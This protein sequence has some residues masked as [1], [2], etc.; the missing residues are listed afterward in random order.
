MATHDFIKLRGLRENNLKG[1][2]LDLP[3]NQFIVVTGLSGSGKS[4]LAFDTIFAEGQRRYTET[5]SPYTRQFLE[6]MNKP[7]ADS[8]EGIPPAIALSQ[9]NS[10]RTSRSTVGS[11]TEIADYLKLLF[12][13]HAELR[14][15]V[16][17]QKIQPW[18]PA[19]IVAELLARHADT[20][21][22]V[23]FDLAFSASISWPAIV[24]TLQ[25]QG[26]TRVLWNDQP[27]RLDDLANVTA[28]APLTISVIADRLTVSAETQSRLA[29]AIQTAL[30]HGKGLV[31]IRPISPIRPIRP[32]TYADHYLDPATHH[33]YTAPTPALF[34][35]NSPIGACPVCKGFGRTVTIDYDLA[36]PD[37]TLTISGGVVKCFSGQTMQECQRDLLKACRKHRIP[38]NIPFNQLT[39][40]QQK[41]V[42][43][44]EITPGKTLEQSYDDGEWYG[45]SGFFKWLEMRTYKMNV[46]ILIARYRAYHP[47]PACHGDRFKPETTLWQLHGKTITTIN[48]TPLRDL[49]PWFANLTVSDASAKILLHQITARLAYLN[50]VG[51]GYLTLGR[52]SRTLS[53]GELQRV[54]L[55]T[56]LGTS[57]VGTLF[58]LDEPSIGLH[59]RDTAQLTNILKTLARQGNTVL[60]VEHDAAIIRAADHLIELGPRGGADGGHL[61]HSGHPD[62]FQTSNLK[63]QINS[64]H[65]ISNS[66]TISLTA[67]YLS[68]RRVIPLPDKRRSVDEHTP[69]LAFSGAS[70]HNI[71]HLAGQIPLGKFTAITGVSGSGKSTLVRDIIAPAVKT[72][73]STKPHRRRDAGAVWNLKSGIWSLVGI[74]DLE[75]GICEVL[76][77]DQSPLTR[78][79]RSTPALYLGAYDHIRQLLAGTDSARRLGL[80]P[81]DF[82]FNTGAGRCPRCAG[83]GH[84]KIEMQFLSDVF[85][86][87]PVCDGKRFQDH[88]LTA[89]YRGKNIADLLSLTVSEAIAFFNSSHAKAQTP[90]EQRACLKTAAALHLLEQV[91]LGYLTLGQPTSHLSGGEAQRLK[92]VAELTAAPLKKLRGSASPREPKG[93]LIILDEPTTGLHYEDLRVLLGVL[94]TLVDRGHT[95]LVIEHN[96]E[97]VKCADWVIDL[98]PEAGDQGGQIIA[99]GTPEQ[100]AVHPASRTA[101]Y[102]AQ[103]L[104]GTDADFR[105]AYADFRGTDADFRGAYAD[106]R[107]AYADFRGTYADFREAYADF[108]GTYADLR[109]A[110]ADFRETY[111]DFRGTSPVPSPPAIQITGATHHN[112]KNLTVSIPRQQMTVITGLS[113]SGKSTLAFDLLFAEG[114]RRYL[115]CLNSYARQFIEQLEKPRVDAITGIPPTVAIEQRATRGG[116]KSTVAT[117]TEIYH[118]LRLLYA[119]LGAQHD[120]ATGTPC[121]Q[122]TPAQITTQIKKQ[123]TTAREHLLLAPLI[124]ARKGNYTE[125][126]AWAAKKGYPYL[127]VNGTITPTADF[128]PLNRYR[129]HTIDLIIA[130]LTPRTPNLPA[131]ITQ[132]LDHG[133]GTLIIRPIGTIHPT[134]TTHSTHLYSPAT[135]KSF[136][137]LDPR[138]FSSNS[139]HGWCP[140]CQGYGTLANLSADATLTPLEQEQ[141]QEL[142]REHLD[143]LAATPCPACHGTRL[144]ETARAVR[145][146]GR[147]VT[148]LNAMTVSALDRFLTTLKLK[149]RAAAIA[150]DILPELRQRLQFL[151]HVGLDYLNLDRPAPTLSGGE[152]QRIR[153]AAQLGS[154]LQGVLYILDEPTIGLHPR[155]NAELIKTLRHLQ[156][157]GNTLVIVEHDEATMRAADHIIDLGP[158]AGVNGGQ[159]IAQGTWRAITRN[160]RSLTGK[161]LGAPLPHP[162]R[163]TRRKTDRHTQWLTI[164]NATANN[165]KNLTI[166]LPLGKLIGISGVSGSGKSTLMHKIIIPAVRKK[167]ETRKQKAKISASNFQLSNLVQVTQTPIGKTS[168]S[169]VSTYLGLMDRLRQLMAQLPLAKTRGYTP[170]HFSYNAGPGRCPACQ[171]QGFLK[172]DMNFLPTAYIPCDQCNG[173]RWTAPI[174][175]ITYHDKNIYQILTLSVDEAVEFFAGQPTVQVPLKLLQETGLGYLTLGQTSPTLSGGEAQRLKLVTELASLRLQEHRQR[176]A[177]RAAGAG[178]TLYL[179]EEPTVGLHLA[180]VQRLLEVLHQLV[181]AGHTVIVIEHHLDLLAECDHLIDLGPESGAKGGRVIAAGPPEQIAGNQRSHTGRY[182]R[183]LLYLPKIDAAK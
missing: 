21:V 116:H 34:S 56:C 157:R 15:P 80:T 76:V 178:R 132:A 8:I 145:F 2:D 55:T 86:T 68:G 89:D 51:L 154:N 177:T 79:A 92:L 150:R 101:P 88:V 176:P 23:T 75:F 11:M 85:I 99:E 159:L 40:A 175:E 129:E 126:A 18:T 182:L 120:P 172:I 48:A 36:L 174:L 30:Q 161:L 147:P 110:Y 52:A 118:F 31:T 20:Q 173:Q 158:G 155:D 164:P 24:Q 171:G 37:R 167:I 156:Q 160:R 96:M 50:Q 149:G 169:T 140:R 117:V 64:N 73:L 45:V 119:K 139:P 148:D 5:F 180:D 13:T 91:G 72:M 69:R 47:C 53:G 58:V 144:N 151:R 29:E 16:T 6:R 10:V 61:I 134:E 133:K 66:K 81:A 95:L 38:A 168:R 130:T 107:E 183:P 98:G 143:D 122:Q 114:Q 12:P 138:L 162:M 71:H 26:F 63:P 78:S 113:G 17:G 115:D 33:L 54:N 41:F 46:R 60:V 121:I 124:R 112:L 104:R 106:F 123:L 22:L 67:D 128:K 93:K 35:F 59:P 109:G 7:K 28:S 105:G 179:L 44:G 131:L 9:V 94:Q 49:A 166:K 97:L 42:I 102:L 165:I 77:V 146:A 4:S 90:G 82:S 25:A 1:F 70:K 3:L 141:Q 74:C 181:D 153:L 103:A 32:I 57:L 39:K 163:G 83:A 43:H 19:Q 84:E 62:K 137:P 87:C 142:A 170:A 125:L 135:G 14:S 108:R 127:R 100:I 27:A 65:K 111:A 136:P 152:A